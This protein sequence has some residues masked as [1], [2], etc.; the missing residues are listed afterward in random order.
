VTLEE[1]KYVP[2]LWVNLFSI[3]KALK[4]GFDLR[5]KGLMILL[6]KGTVSITFDRVIKTVHR[7]ISSIKM[8][9]YDPSVAYIVKGS[10]NAIKPE[11][12]P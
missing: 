5:N 12:V 4:N 2:E 1:V 7:S 8:S 3:S 9:R 6:K 10:L 11:Q